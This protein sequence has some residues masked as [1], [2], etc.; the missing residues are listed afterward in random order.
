M[1][2]ECELADC[3]GFAEKYSKRGL[4]DLASSLGAQ[5]ERA[6]VQRRE[7]LKYP[8]TEQSVAWVVTGEGKS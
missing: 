7:E 3:R 4:R 2:P 8:S 5:L 1:Q 6:R